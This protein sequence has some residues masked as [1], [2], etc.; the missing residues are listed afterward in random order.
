MGTTRLVIA[1]M[2]LFGCATTQ[3]ASK[4]S[5]DVTGTWAGTYTWPYGVSPITMT[6]RQAG[7]D[8][9]GD[10]LVTGTLGEV[11]QANG[12]VRG[13]VSGEWLSLTFVGGS[14]DMQVKPNDM[15]GFSSSGSRWSL[16][17]QQ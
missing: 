13:T 10:L 5:V 4:P 9:T 6:L 2:I 12:P 3:S 16:Q 8:V 15:N 17:R 14:A 1:C 11:R 7:A